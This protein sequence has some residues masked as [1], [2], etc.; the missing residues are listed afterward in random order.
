MVT[1]C[2][3][4]AT[5]DRRKQGVHIEQDEV[6]VRSEA[7]RLDQPGIDPG[8]VPPF[9]H[10]ASRNL[11]EVQD[12]P[13]PQ[14]IAAPPHVK[15]DD[16]ALIRRSALLLK[17]EVP[18]EDCEEAPANVYQPFDR[19]RNTRN[20]GGREAREDLTHDP[21]RGRADNLTDSKDDGVERGR[22]S[23]LY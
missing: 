5:D 7:D 20:P 16:R 22:V 1:G 18:V 13:D 6:L 17:Q 3:R 9:D 2:E 12:L 8:Q 11:E 10:R 4:L 15:H 19:I 14:A 23:H 21:C